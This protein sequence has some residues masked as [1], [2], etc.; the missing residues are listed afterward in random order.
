MTVSASSTPTIIKAKDGDCY[1][2]R[3]VNAHGVCACPDRKNYVP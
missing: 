2:P 1:A 3:Q